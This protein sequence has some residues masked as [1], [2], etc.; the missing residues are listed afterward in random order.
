S[1]K[2]VITTDE[3]GQF[4]VVLQPAMYGLRVTFLGYQALEHSSVKISNE[5]TDLGEFHL[6]L[7]EQL[8]EEAVVSHQ[9]KLVEQRSDRLVVNVENSVLSD[10][11]TALE[12]L[13]RA[14][15]VRV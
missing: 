8:L 3:R 11:L 2:K 13:Q 4:E 12:I 6:Q 9:R 14:P 10:G 5:A 1:A 15:G 7:D